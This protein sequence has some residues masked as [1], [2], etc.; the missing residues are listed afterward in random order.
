MREGDAPRQEPFM[1][2]CV[3]GVKDFHRQAKSLRQRTFST[4]M[5]SLDWRHIWSLSDSTADSPVA[6]KTGVDIFAE[7]T[8][9]AAVDG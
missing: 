4:S 5:K 8:N 1:V 2:L 9:L 3:Q 7:M 6:P